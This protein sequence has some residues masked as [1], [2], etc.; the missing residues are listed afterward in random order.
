MSDPLSSVEGLVFDVFG[1]V[2]DWRTTVTQELQLRAHRKLTSSSSSDLPAA[3]STT[4]WARFAHD[5]HATYITFT[6][7]FDPSS[8]WKSVD[9]HYRDS[10]AQLLASHGLD[11]V[12]SESEL[13]SLSLVWHRLQPWDDAPT[14]LEALA[15]LPA[16]SSGKPGK[17]LPLSTL[18]N[19]NVALLRD[20]V[21]FGGLAFSKLLSAETFGAYKPAPQVYHG[22]ARELGL[23]T[24]RVALVAAHLE[25]L[26]AARAC[27][28][29]TVYVERPDEEA[30]PVDDPR[31]KEARDWV[32][33]WIA[34]GDG[35]FH[36]LAEHLGR[37]RKN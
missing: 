35:G 10:L 12:F 20:L 6:R 9:A 1:T 5:W 27:G 30:W 19:G 2:V 34:E 15:A 11:G 28:L 14:A 18:S 33:L 7:S 32:D 31:R 23:D 4:D 8:P 25:D 21:D 17:K 29:R 37:L 36:R 3:L 22:A 13:E 26:A 16:D 24:S